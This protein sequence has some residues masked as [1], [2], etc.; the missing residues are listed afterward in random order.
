MV[1]CRHLA[2][3]PGKE[4]SGSKNCGDIKYLRI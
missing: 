3:Q 2:C 1:T 4:C